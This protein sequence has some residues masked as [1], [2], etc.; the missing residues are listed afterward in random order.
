[1]GNVV[2]NFLRRAILLSIK[3]KYM[4]ELNTL[5]GN[6]AN[7]FLR[8]EILLNIKGQYMN[9]SCTDLWAFLSEVWSC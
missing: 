6:V 4:K 5:A 2:N 8:R 7:N 9:E 3:G 1:M